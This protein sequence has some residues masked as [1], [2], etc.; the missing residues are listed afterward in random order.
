VATELIV[1]GMKPEVVATADRLSIIKAKEV[2]PKCY[3]SSMLLH[4]ANSCRYYQFK[5][6]LSNNTTK[7][8]DNYPKTIV[9]TMHIL[10]NNVPPPRLQRM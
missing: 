5:M 3:L 6:D 9:K 1:Q 7:G 2:C 10:T 4:G 8:T